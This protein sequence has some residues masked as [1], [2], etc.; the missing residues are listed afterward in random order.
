ME[1][2]QW[3]D[4]ILF[5]TSIGMKTWRERCGSA[6]MRRGQSAAVPKSIPA[7]WWTNRVGM[8]E[9]P[10]AHDV[11]DRS[12]IQTNLNTRFCLAGHLYVHQPQHVASFHKRSL[13]R[14][15][16]THAATIASFWRGLPWDFRDRTLWGL[17]P[18]TGSLD[19]VS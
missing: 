14:L 19:A 2:F 9:T 4:M 1:K 3:A 18:K 6:S 5:D 16:G 13:S 12:G 7:M 10:S 11:I 8:P 15:V 17:G